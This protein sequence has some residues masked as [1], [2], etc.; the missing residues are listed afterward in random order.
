MEVL[1]NGIYRQHVNWAWSVQF[2][3][4]G[5]QEIVHFFLLISLLVNEIF[6]SKNLF[7]N[8]DLRLQQKIGKVGVF[9]IS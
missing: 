2:F 8:F 6:T 9:E 7:K 5:N 3:P 4:G 1:I